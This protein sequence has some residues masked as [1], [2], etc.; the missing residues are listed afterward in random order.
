[1]IMSTNIDSLQI[2]IVSSS[3][4]AV[5]SIQSLA[6]ALGELKTNSKITTAV[7]NLNNLRKALH[8]FANI[9]SN[10]SKVHSLAGSLEKLKEVGS[11][12]AIGNSLTKLASSLQS[13]DTVRVNKEKI[14]SI[15]N[16]LGSLSAVKA[17]GI[18]TMMNGLLK[19]GKVTESLN[20]E[21]IDA[22][23][24]RIEKL[25]EKLTPLSEKMTTIQ[26]GLKGINSAARSAGSSAK[27]MGEDVD[28]ASVNFASLIYT[29]QEAIQWTQQAIEKFTKFM[30]EAIEWDGIASRFGRGF[31]D[32]AQET[33]AWIQRLNEEMGINVQQFMKYSSVY[34]TMLTGFGVANEDATKMALGYT[35]LTYDIW[36]GYN[37]IYKNFDDAAEAVKSAIAGEVEPIR[38]AGFTIVESTLEQTAANHGLSISLEKATESQ[39][40]YLRYLTLVD[41][42][43]SQGLVGTYAKELQTAEGLM[44]TFSQQLK[45]LTQAFGSLF[46]PVLVNIMPYLQAF[47]ELLTE[48]I[49]AIAA[50]FGITIQ[51]VD[52]SGY[53]DG[54]GGVA[55]GTNDLAD[56]AGNATDAI[57]ELKNASLGID[58]LNVI[59]P[60][61][62]N[63]G[64]G[65]AGGSGGSNGF[66]N[67]D[68]DSLWDDSIFADIGNQVDSIKEKLKS[69]LPVIEAIGAVFGTLGIALLIAQLGESMEAIGKMNG[70]VGELKKTLAGLAILTIEAVLVFMLADEYL[71]SG[72]LLALVGEALATAAGGYLMYKGFGAKGLTMSLVVSIAAQLAAITLNLADGGVEMDDPQL[73]IQS[74]FTVAT[75]GVAGGFLSYKG[76][77]K[78]TTGQGVTFGVLAGLSLSLAAITIG[79]ITADGLNLTNAI[80]GALSTIAGGAAGAALVTF[81]GIATGGTGFLIGTAVMLAVNVIG[82][83]VGSVSKDA[84][85]S[86]EDDLNSRFGEIELTVEETKAYVEKITAIPREVVIDANVW[87]EELEDYEVQTMTVPVGVAL[88]IFDTENNTLESLRGSVNNI[89]EKVSRDAMKITLG[90]EVSH[91]DYTASIDTYISNAQEY[92]DQYYLT[93]SI[94]IG[95]SPGDSGDSLTNTLSA[96]YTTSSAELQTLGEKLKK[97]VSEAF[98]DGE[99]IPNKLQEALEIQKEIQEIIDYTT[100][101]EY[102][103]TIQNL[104]LSVSGTDLTPESFSGVLEG[105]KEAIEK[106]LESLEEVKMSKLQ[107]AIM[108]YDAN[109]ADGMSEAE[110]K[111]IYEQTVADIEAEYQNGRV[112][113]QYGTV[114]FG[115]DTLRTAFAAEIKRAKDAGWFNYEE[116]VDIVLNDV[117]LSVDKVDMGYGDIYTGIDMMMRDIA[118]YYEMETAGVSTET[119]ENLESLLETMKPTMADYE[120]IAAECR[121]AGR[122]VPENVRAGLN[123]YNEIAALTGDA[124]AI[125]YMIGQQF[126]TDPVF[127][128]TLAT[129]KGAGG[130]VSSE[131]AEGLLNNIEVVENAADETV[132][133]L[134]NGIEVGTYD[135]TPTLKQN[136]KDLGINLSDGLLDGAESEMQTNKKSWR[137]WAIW[138]WN[139]FKEKNEINSPS[140][141]FERGGKYLTDGLVNGMEKDS[142]SN[143]LSDVWAS[144]KSWWDGKKGNLSTYTPSIGNI[145]TKLS[146]AWES[147]KTWWKEKRSSLSY[148]PT[149]GKIW[150]KLKSAW[151]TAKDW[152]NKNRS[153]LSYT[154]SI[155]SIKTKLSSAWTSAKDW[156]NKNRSSLSYT[157]SIGS[158][159]DKVISAWNSAKNWWKNNVGGLSTKLNISVPKIKVNWDTAT[160]FGKSFKYPTGFKLEFAADGGIF[161][162]GSLVWAGERGPEIV[163]NA[164]GGKTGVM[165]VQQMQDA[166]YEGV[167]AAVVAAMGAAGG[168]SD[169]RPVNVYLDGRQI[170]AAVEK[171]QH[172]RGA[173]IM[174][175]QVYSY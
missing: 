103:A 121:K 102:R 129:V 43:Q 40:S 104:K 95:I 14:D 48:G 112:E 2:E 15:A 4:S 78:L 88:E 85:K 99:W 68:V 53:Q 91:E 128:N 89:A 12:A 113:V 145:S 127:L 60:P 10:A 175:N 70:L 55:D 51:G 134:S 28:G 138:P 105:S 1:M 72:N 46:L 76:L 96:F 33:Y 169:S 157:P 141:L 133:I 148:T 3:A 35:E 50:L 82:A 136:M 165:N 155:G 108:Q 80:T 9:P 144:A 74:A 94:A 26:A 110:A 17:G 98:V 29:I 107:V 163:A 65:G 92:M 168:N 159:K 158:I 160:A 56:S 19:M 24:E 125:N 54:I 115:L 170:T 79:D 93:T 117:S 132:T 39:K 69:W 153:N 49:Q 66:E 22:F 87:N 34:A 18:N 124:Q 25:T 23:A 8:S 57:K 30:A 119:R 84:E 106:K 140:K 32:Q 16:S 162:Q 139:W 13:L 97:T 21:A 171:R 111:K 83:I 7:N 6:G 11:V 41:Q 67:L 143:R 86:L 123:D 61:T 62:A 81:L 31:G 101:V 149:I 58:E 130:A 156:W 64:S 42:A 109:I 20:D 38:R 172:E 126:S 122:A 146:S 151:T 37:D 142:L 152:W 36:A 27:K 150:E 73:W 114:S 173:S 77:T 166:V 118:N 167:Y 45:S 147:A 137:D 59:S 164:S 135:A 116:K 44:R 5:Q 71:E 174:G 52:W 75:A 120:D 161:N 90:I 47:V 131:V 154:P 100:D 63:G